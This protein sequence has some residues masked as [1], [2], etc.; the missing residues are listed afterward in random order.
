MLFSPPGWTSI[1]WNPNFSHSIDSYTRCDTKWGWNSFRPRSRNM[2]TAVQSA[3]I[4]WILFLSILKWLYIYIYH[5]FWVFVLVMGHFQKNP[6]TSKKVF[7]C[8]GFSNETVQFS[9]KTSY[10]YKE[11]TRHQET[12]YILQI[13]LSVTFLHPCF[14]TCQVQ[15]VSDVAQ[16]RIC[17]R[18]AYT[19]SD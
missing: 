12:K 15:D 13:H 4:Q 6:K 14:S 17:I 2:F 8:W 3:V 16:L 7:T 1:W 9:T 18:S 11:C 5:L 19:S 10:G